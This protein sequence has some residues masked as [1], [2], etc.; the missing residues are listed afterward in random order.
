MFFPSGVLVWVLPAAA[1]G[2][3]AHLSAY[4]RLLVLLGWV[5][6]VELIPLVFVGFH[7]DFLTVL[8]LVEGVFDLGIISGFLQSLNEDG[9]GRITLTNLAE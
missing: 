2:S 9:L 4:L 7:L 1:A 3:F 6:E 8:Q 5:F